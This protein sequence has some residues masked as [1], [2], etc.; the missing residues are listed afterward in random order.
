MGE[1]DGGESNYQDVEAD[2][3][4]KELEELKLSL[5][6]DDLNFIEKLD[7]IDW[8]L[9][10]AKNALKKN[11]KLEE[12]KKRADEANKRAEEEKQRADE[13]KQRAD[14][15]DDDRRY[16]NIFTKGFPPLGL[17]LAGSRNPST[18]NLGRHPPVE[19][20][21]TFE[22]GMME[23]EAS[24]VQ[25]KLYD[26]IEHVYL[27]IPQG[28]NTNNSA[29][30]S[31]RSEEEIQKY[32]LS[33][34][35]EATQYAHVEKII[36]FST[37]HSLLFQ[38]QKNR[39]NTF[40]IDI[41]GVLVENK[42]D[43]VGAIEMKLPFSGLKEA[44]DRCLKSSDDPSAEE[45]EETTPKD[46]IKGY[47]GQLYDYLL[48]L[49]FYY[50]VKRPYGILSFYT[51]FVVV[52]PTI[53]GDSEEMLRDI[54]EDRS[55][56]SGVQA[57]PVVAQGGL[58]GELQKIPVFGENSS[59]MELE[60]SLDPLQKQPAYS[61]RKVLVSNPISC[62]TEGPVA[63]KQLANVLYLMSQTEIEAGVRRKGQLCICLGP[64]VSKWDSLPSEIQ[65]KLGSLCPA[66]TDQFLFYQLAI[67]GGGRDGRCC[68]VADK[69]GR[70]CVLKFLTVDQD[71]AKKAENEASRWRSIWN[72]EAWS[73]KVIGE[74]VVGM[75][76]VRT[77]RYLDVHLA[78]VK[79]GVSEA[80]NNSRRKIEEREDNKFDSFWL[81]HLIYDALKRMAD[82]GY[83]HNDLICS[84]TGQLKLE[85][86]GL[87]QRNEVCECVFIDLHDMKRDVDPKNALKSMLKEVELSKS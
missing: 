58:H 43:L 65:I 76:F 21:D 70:T 51:H 57:R 42:N 80:R 40:R 81:G 78:E 64:D 27:Q 79:V 25:K 85:H 22:V 61:A 72:F 45:V 5:D 3:L 83:R 50:G 71:R 19:I 34:C 41:G 75:P 86:V 82:K 9:D 23:G 62:C 8:K 30:F 18:P 24:H 38:E 68:L 63:G 1:E 84:F 66:P 35:L 6:G 73:A 29:K 53:V 16:P 15:G 20:T 44:I 7:S 26:Q 48:I 77:V 13:E 33:A 60:E 59:V 47:L 52:I 39:M 36:G 28:D 37:S 46:R 32:F 87:I 31:Y 17:K 74:D 2:R 12:E 4:S 67:F 10:Y 55:A 14:Q 49:Y 11:K 69:A 54:K 56:R